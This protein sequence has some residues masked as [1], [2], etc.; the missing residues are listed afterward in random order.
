[1]RIVKEFLELHYPEKMQ[2]NSFNY[3]VYHSLPKIF[4][5]EVIEA[6][7]YVLKIDSVMVED[8]SDELKIIDKIL[9][10]DCVT[11]STTYSSEIKASITYFSKDDSSNSKHT[12]NVSL[13]RLPVMVGSCLCNLKDKT[14]VMK[15]Y[16]IVKGAKKA[17]CMEERIAYNY[18][19][20][21]S[22]K[23]EFKFFKYVEFKSMNSIFRSSM[24]DVGAKNIKNKTQILVYCP[25]LTLRELLPIEW[26]LILFLK[27]EEIKTNLFNITQSVPTNYQSE[28]SE[29]IVDNF[30]FDVDVNIIYEA[31]YSYNERIESPKDVMTILKERFLIHMTELSIHEKGIFVMY[32]LKILLYGLVDFI[33]IDDRDHYGNKRVYTVNHFF[34]SELN[35]VFHKK[36]KKKLI[37]GLDKQFVDHDTIKRLIEK[38]QEITNSFKNCLSSNSWHGKTQS[39]QYVSQQFDPFNGL[40]YLDL[41]RKINTPVKNDSNKILGPRDLHLTQV[42]ILCPYGT[43]DGKKVGLVKYPSIQSILTVDES[44]EMNTICKELCK[45]HLKEI[46][47]SM[48]LLL[49]NGHC[50]GSIESNEKDV[51][52]KKLRR[53]KTDYLKHETSVYFSEKLNAIIILSDAG[54]FLYPIVVSRLCKDISFTASLKKGYI[55]LLDKNEVEDVTLA[56]VDLFID[57]RDESKMDFVFSFSLGFLGSLIPYSNHNQAPRNIYQC[58]MSKQAVGFLTPEDRTSIYNSLCYPQIP[59]V[60][61]LTHY[62]PFIYE[63]PTGINAVVSI[64]PY[65]GENQEDSIILNKSSLDRGLFNSIRE[66]TFRHTLDNADVLHSPAS[67]N[68]TRTV[69][70]FEKLD[71]KGIIKVDS[72]VKKNDVLISVKRVDSDRVSEPV[73]VFPNDDCLAQIK[74][75]KSILTE[76]GE[77]VITIVAVELLIPQIGDKFSSRHGQKGTVGMIVSQEDMPFT[78]DGM[79]PDIIINPLCIPSRMTIGHLLEMSSGIDICKSSPN[80]FCSVCLVYKKNLKSP[81][82]EKDCFLQNTLENYLHHTAFYMELIPHHIKNFKSTLMYCG[83]T[84]KIMQCLIFTGVIYYQRL[85]HMSRDKVYV[86][87]IGPI[88]PV[89]R[90]PKEG[91]SVE[92]GHRFGLQERDCIL[93]HGCAFALRDRLFL[94]SD[95]HKVYICECGIIYHGK[96][97][98]SYSYAQCKLCKSFKIYHVEL[99]FASKVLI[100]LLMAFNIN[101]KL[102]PSLK[103]SE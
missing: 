71:K 98:K 63:H 77:T 55:L 72:Y 44:Y 36:F 41:I 54:R 6:N 64:M 51:V 48:L 53:L 102:I 100:Q 23:K 21:L 57:S 12:I 83:L 65:M 10:E 103:K 94:N 42:D 40:H 37:H 99:P 46:S 81:R 73:L 82:C 96:D 49:V 27:V 11:L 75:V 29:I 3:F 69:Y 80:K 61:T 76:K 28:I 8:A 20:L 22:K 62:T 95:Y 32:L 86:R 14:D 59:L 70:N 16:F 24:I 52:L 19:F 84:G 85:K 4:E 43:P 1:M 88:Q 45:D 87:T 9:P 17:I 39:A 56:E 26:F 68:S 2:L 101:M 33:Q 38:N 66:I 58:Q 47:L 25:E 74:T 35:H 13:G 67:E 31:V 18:P 50:I 78:E 89:T 90:Q 97:P 92:G 60:G 93:A 15:C 7:N 5:K 30:S 79:V 91:R 34:T